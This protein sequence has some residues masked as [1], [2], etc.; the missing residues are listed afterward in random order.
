MALDPHMEDYLRLSLHFASAMTARNPF[1]AARAATTFANQY[2]SARDSLEQTDADRAFWLVI[3]AVEIIDYQLPFSDEGDAL[4]LIDQAGAYLSEALELD[5]MCWDARRMSAAAKSASP[6]DYV[7]YL[8]EHADEVRKSCEEACDK[9]RS[10]NGAAPLNKD[11]KVGVNQSRVALD[12]EMLEVAC[13]LA[14][15]PYVRWLASMAAIQLVCGRYRLSIKAAQ[16][17]LE[18]DPDDNADVSF[19][20]ALAYAK[21]EDAEAL[22]KLSANRPQEYGEAWFSL[23]RM[24]LAFKQGNKQ[25]AQDELE[26]LLSTYPNAALTLSLQNDIPDGVYS[27]ILVEPGSEDELILAVSEATVLL[28]EGC[29][30]HERGTIGSW[31]AEQPAI[32]EALK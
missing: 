1:E 15:R 29:D 14:Q 19:T 9:L 32:K 23:A 12:A 11:Y 8:V 27:R 31:L 25:G 21:L 2:Q 7:H 4:S 28:Q 5:S 20:L 22:E 30:I 3:K 26:F 17:A 6:N 10:A 16:Q 13:H 24:A 18:L